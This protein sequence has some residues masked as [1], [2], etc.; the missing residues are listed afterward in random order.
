MA[1]TLLKS[2]SSRRQYQNYSSVINFLA[3]EENNLSLSHLMEVLEKFKNE[4]LSGLLSDENL[5]MIREA[6]YEK[7]PKKFQA[8]GINSRT[9]EFIS[10][11]K[12]LFTSGRYTFDA[13]I[14]QR[15]V[16][17]TSPQP[18]RPFPKGLDVFAAVG[19][20]T[21]EDILLNVYNENQLWKDYSDT[22]NVLKKKFQNFSKWD[23]SIYNKQMETILTLQSINKNAPYFMKSP[24]WQLK[25]LNTM[26]SSWTE[27][28]HD[29]LL[30]IE[31][32]SGAEMG[33]GGEVPPPQKIA[34]VEPQIEFWIKCQELLEL[35]DKFL[36]NLGFL[37]EKLKYR[38]SELIKVAQLL[39]GVSQ[40][41]IK[42]EYLNTKE[43]DDL[44]FLGGRIEHLTLNII[45]SDRMSVYDVAT[46]EKYL[47]V[48]A[49]VYTYRDQCLE[50]CVG[51]G[52]EIYAVVE[53][54]GLLYIARGGVFSQYEFIQPTSSRLTD[55]KW[56]QQLLEN[57]IPAVAT[58]LS[59]IKINV[60]KLETRPHFNLY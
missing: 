39:L 7:D 56:Q 14:L 29:M 17:V 11:K 57:E 49:D 47:A 48:A 6:L 52:D 10:R 34:Y 55:E 28:K 9:E 24:S 37:S 40:K 58:W 36:S 54:N 4:S 26:L 13:E 8:R 16:H 46:P 22:L 21:A 59:K 43:F 38:N 5:K 3:G 42:G 35:N 33:D 2:E 20:K 44:S 60:E 51:L 18:K 41:E 19:N 23:A 1:Y 25:N 12:V 15:I 45:E 50:E 53:I 32:P 27:L 31:Q 30:Y